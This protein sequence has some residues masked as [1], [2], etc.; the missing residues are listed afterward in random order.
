MLTALTVLAVLVASACTSTQDKKVCFRGGCFT[1]EAAG[2]AD[3]RARGLM[4]REKLDRN[5]GMLFVFDREGVYPFWMKNML[6]PVDIVWIN[7]SRDV[8]YISKNTL[9]CGM[10]DCPLVTPDA[11]ATYVLEINAGLADELNLAVGD[12][13]EIQLE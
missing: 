6:I 11:K 2:T 7:Q 10:E 12:K 3:E 5:S 9:P 8:V 4:F 13:A 1:V